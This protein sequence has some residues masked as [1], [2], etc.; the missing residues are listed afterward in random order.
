MKLAKFMK[1][2]PNL[3]IDYNVCNADIAI[4]AF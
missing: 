1:L 3:S 2:H 4:K